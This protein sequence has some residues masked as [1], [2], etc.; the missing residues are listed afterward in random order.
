V[1]REPDIEVRG[2]F[3]LDPAVPEPDPAQVPEQRQLVGEEAR[4]VAKHVRGALRDIAGVVGVQGELGRAGLGRIRVVVLRGEIEPAV[5]GPAERE[6]QQKPGAGDEE[7]CQ[8]AG[9]EVSV[10]PGELVPVV[11]VPRPGPRVHDPAP[12]GGVGGRVEE[13]L[14]EVEHTLQPESEL[15]D[16][17]PVRRLVV[18]PETA[19]RL[20]VLRPERPVVH[21]E[22][23][24][25]PEERVGR[26]GK[27]GRPTEIEPIRLGVVRVLEELLQ[28]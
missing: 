18:Q 28:D 16:R 2:T 22:Q 24:R 3:R 11:V 20:G 23:P 9:D 7:R 5:F 27:P 25:P 13:G 4:L 19:D 6:P 8:M 14:A 15:A 26:A 10:L 17:T 21:R 12:G 1:G